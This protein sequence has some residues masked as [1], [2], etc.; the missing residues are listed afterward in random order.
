[1]NCG[2]LHT[3]GIQEQK[4]KCISGGVMS[5][6]GVMLGGVHVS[7]AV[8][9]SGFF[10]LMPEFASIRAQINTMHIDMKSKK[11]CNSCTKRRLHANI[12]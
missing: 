4:G 1:L 5:K 9:D 8:S 12:D 2:N 10:Q 7:K 11:V 6:P 3:V